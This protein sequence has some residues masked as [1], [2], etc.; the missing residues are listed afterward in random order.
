MNDE[1]HKMFLT[2]NASKTYR[3]MLEYD[4]MDELLTQS[5]ASVALTERAMENTDRRYWN[6][7][8]VI[9]AFLFAVMLWHDY[10]RETKKISVKI[11]N[12]ETRFLAASKIIG[13]LHQRV[14]IQ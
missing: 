5:E 4:L 2:G 12:N 14:A 11:G 3:S 7:R 10:H 13:R 1:F 8:P 6:D 9:A